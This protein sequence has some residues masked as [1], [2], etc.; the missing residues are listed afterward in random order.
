MAPASF[1]SI[2]CDQKLKAVVR[3][4]KR[5]L[6]VP[7][8]RRMRKNVNLSCL[9]NEPFPIRSNRSAVGPKFFMKTACLAVNTVLLPNWQRALIK[10]IVKILPFR[11]RHNFLARRAADMEFLGTRPMSFVVL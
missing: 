9:N 10:P 6:K 7:A 4:L 11:H 2:V 5:A 1:R 3:I 8:D